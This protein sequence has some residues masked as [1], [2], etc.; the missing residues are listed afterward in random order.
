MLGV[1]KCRRAKKRASREKSERA[2][3][4]RLSLPNPN[5]IFAHFYFFSICFPHHLGAWNRLVK[6]AHRWVVNHHAT[7]ATTCQSISQYDF[8]NKTDFRSTWRIAIYAVSG[9]LISM[10]GFYYVTPLPFTMFQVSS[11]HTIFTF[12]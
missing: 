9:P 4:T 1:G 2:S 5:A 8:R 12:I 11:Y 10:L 7:K 3:E 6:M